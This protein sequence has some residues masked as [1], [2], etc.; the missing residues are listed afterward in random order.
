MWQEIGKVTSEVSVLRRLLFGAVHI[1]DSTP[2]RWDII[3][4]FAF[5]HSTR[6]CASTDVK[7]LLENVEFLDREAFATDTVLA[8]EL[9]SVKRPNGEPLGVVLISPNTI[10][11]LCGGTLL[12]RVDRPS[13]VTIY[14]ETMGTVPATHFYKYC[15][16]SRKGCSF[17]QHYSYSTEGEGSESMY[18]E[19]WQTL[20]FFVSTHKT[21]FEMQFLKR[22]D[23]EILIG[24][25]TYNQS[26]DI[27]NYM[28]RYGASCEA[29]ED[30][31]RGSE[32]NE[33]YMWFHLCI[34]YRIIWGGGGEGER[35]S[36][37]PHPHTYTTRS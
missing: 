30:T 9:L 27:Y 8:S 11:K 19:D 5:Q 4:D 34:V 37:L 32:D 13:R 14:S 23:A 25:I 24:Q 36:T 29:N 1:P 2:N 33:R 17:T 12:T 26:C 7:L 18:D 21:A 3:S 31:A 20:P 28:H 35:D 16:N 6:K 22:L 10:C 15:Q